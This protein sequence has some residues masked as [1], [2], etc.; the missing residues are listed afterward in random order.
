H[1][2]IRLH[3]I[4]SSAMINWLTLPCGILSLFNS[5]GTV[6]LV[7]QLNQPVIDSGDGISRNE[8]GPKAVGQANKTPGKGHSIAD[9]KLIQQCQVR[10]D[11]GATLQDQP[12]RRDK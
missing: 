2:W 4:A 9:K 10:A 5:S 8:S 1:C 3:S 7:L 12:V 6:T 11:D